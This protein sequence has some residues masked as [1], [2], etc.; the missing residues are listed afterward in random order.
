MLF[1]T[2]PTYSSPAAIQSQRPSVSQAAAQSLSR[3][4]DAANRRR[5]TFQVQVA[6]SVGVL[7]DGARVDL[8]HVHVAVVAGDDHVV[9]LVVVER[10][11]GVAL[12]QRRAVAQVEHIMD[13]PAGQEWT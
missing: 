10:L 9:P 13:V 3:S 11:V 7:R 6:G 8:E 5:L 2:P 1:P 12:H 4:V